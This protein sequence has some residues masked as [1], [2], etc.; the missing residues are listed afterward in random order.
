[1]PPSL[2]LWQLL[3]VH[4]LGDFPLQSRAMV[5]LRKRK[6]ARTP[7]VWAHGGIH[8]LLF[9]LVAGHW[10]AGLWALAYGL[11]HVAIDVWKSYRPNT[12]RYF[13]IDQALHVFCL[14]LCWAYAPLQGVDAALAHLASRLNTQAYALL[15]P[16]AALFEGACHMLHNAQGLR[17]A[18]GALVLW[19]PYPLVV[20]QLLVGIRPMLPTKGLRAGGQWIGRLERMLTF[21]FVLAGQWAAIGFLLTAKS[22]LRLP[23]V[24]NPAN[25]AAAEYVIVGTL[26]SIGGAIGIGWLCTA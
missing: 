18:V 22:I 14:L 1:M 2:L 26:L 9:L 20:A 5:V 10:Q 19:F 15:V 17:K 21:G 16:I 8:A 12:L 24:Q 13:F 11:T 25:R 3:L 23:E 6:H 4:L 7:W